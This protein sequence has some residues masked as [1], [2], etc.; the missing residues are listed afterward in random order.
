[1]AV[2]V[3]QQ[4]KAAGKDDLAAHVADARVALGHGEQVG[5]PVGLD[6][7]VVVEEGHV[8]AFPGGGLGQQPVARRGRAHVDREA[9]DF[10]LVFRKELL[11]P[12]GHG[13]AVVGAA[14]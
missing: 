4:G 5:Q 8:F 3:L 7:D 6:V 9:D 10:H 14:I 12:A 2:E 13:Q 1:M 11:G